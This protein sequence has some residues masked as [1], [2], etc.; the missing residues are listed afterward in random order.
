MSLTINLP[1]AM[2]REARG[3]QMLEGTTLEQMFLDYLR[4]EFERKRAAVRRV[5]DVDEWESQFDE[6][7]ESSSVGLEGTE[8]YKFNRADAYPEG[9]FA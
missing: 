9:E 7:V 6:L 4:K 5:E 3:Y 2:E 8:P 1:P